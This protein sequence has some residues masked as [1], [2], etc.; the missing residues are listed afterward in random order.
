MDQF[1][2]ISDFAKIVDPTKHVN[3]IDNWFKALEERR[4]HYVNRIAGAKV[5]DE[6][7]LDIARFIRDKRD[8][9]PRWSMDGIFEILPEQFELR[10]F[11]K[12]EETTRVPQVTDLEVFRRELYSMAEQIAAAQVEEVKLQ[13]AELMRQLPK[14]VDPAEERQT[15]I[16]DLITQRRVL[17]ELEDEALQMWS[18]KPQQ[19][20]MM[21][22]GLFRSV[23]NAEAK[24]RF[25]REY[26]NASLEQRLQERYGLHMEQNKEPQTD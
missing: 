11:P 8:K 16:S 3:T 5:Y 15:R 22:V 10:P 18:T 23:E 26:I 4:L 6:L 20:R 14:P 19:E 2:Q 21:K 7:D 17:A 13:Y 25:I 1:Y 9:K 24:A 12:E